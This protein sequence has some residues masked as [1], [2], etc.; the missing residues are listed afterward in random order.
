MPN[1][2]IL[3]T[4]GAGFIGS[5]LVDR[6]LAEGANVVAI[7]NF[8]LGRPENVAHLAGN[9][10]F[11]FEELDVLDRPG[12]DKLFQRHQFSAVFHM[13]ANSD[14]G[15]GSADTERDLQLTFRSTF[16]VLDTMRRHQVR[17]IVFASSSAIYGEREEQLT[18]DAGPWQPVS[19]Y[20]AGKLA[21]EAYVSA[22]VHSFDLQAWICRFPNVVGERATHGVVYDFMQRLRKDPT[23]LRILGNGEQ[24]KPYLYVRDLVDAMLFIWKKS[25]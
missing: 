25:S 5:H 13:A 6:L 1:R 2:T 9:P 10:G 12:L 23:R 24:E 21:A 19:L 7:D 15:R 22:F 11:R 17:Q 8:E 14:I 16:E 18:E 3:V 4:G 20:G